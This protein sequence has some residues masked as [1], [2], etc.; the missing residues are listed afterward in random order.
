MI[1]NVM[2]KL[3]GNRQSKEMKRLQPLID[4]INQYFGQYQSLSDE[5]LREKTDEFKQRIAAGET[6]D[7]ILPEAFAVVKE[8]CRRHLGKTWNA[9]ESPITWDMVPFDVQLAGAIALHEGK[10]AEMAT[11]E[12]KTLAATMPLYLNALPGRGAHLVTVNDYL[13]RRDAEWMGEIYRFLGMSIG[14][15]LTN[16]PPDQRRGQYAC[17]ITYGTNN[18]FGFDY[19]RDNMAESV[20]HLVQR[21]HF[22]AIID[23]VD[24]VLIDEAR[25][26]LIIS[27]PVER[28]YHR[29][30]K[31]KPFVQTLVHNQTLLVN[32]LLSEAEAILKDEPDSFEAGKRILQAKKGSPK[33]TRLRKILAEP[34]YQRLCTRVE[35]D[36]MINK[37]IPELE[38][39]LFYVIDERGHNIDLTEQGRNCISPTDPEMFVLN[40]IVEEIQIIDAKTDID[41]HNKEE[42]KTQAYEK[43][44]I[45][46]E[47]LHNISQLLRAYSLYEQ[48]VEYIVQ[49]N[50]VI[51]VDEFTGRLMPGRRYSDGL[52]QALEAKEGVK[53]ER[54]TQTFATVTLQNFFRLYEKL[55]GMTGT[56]ETEEA[57]FVH[58]YNMDVNVM[59]TNKPVRRLDYN[60]YIYKTKREKYNAIIEEIERLHG[61][62]LPVLVGTVSVEVSELLSRMLRRK[63]ISHNVLNAKNHLREAEIIREAGQP[64][65]VTIAT[66]MAGRGTDIKLG[67][68]VVDCK[69]CCINC[70]EDCDSY[71]QCV[72][73]SEKS[74]AKFRQC[75]QDVPCGLY[76]IG[77]ERHESRRIDRQL[78]GRSGRQGD[79]GASR[80]FIS[81]EDDLMRLFGSERIS[82]IMTKLG[83]AE[84]ERIEHRLI[85]RSIENAQKKIEMIN[86][87]RRKHTLEYD[88][89]M[90]KQREIIYGL[91][92]EILMAE[93]LK[94]TI[95]ELCLE[96]T[97]DLFDQYCPAGANP[98]EWDLRGFEGWLR[99]N[100]M[101][102]DLPEL[103]LHTP[104]EDL[105]DSAKEAVR[106]G[107]DAKETMLGEKLMNHI[108]QFFALRA[109]D[110]E[111]REHLLAVDDL[112]DS[113]GLRA[114]AQRDPLQEYKAEA[115]DLFQ[116]LLCIIRKEIFEKIFR[117]QIVREESRLG[118]A[119]DRLSFSM[120]DL[121]ASQFSR[122][123]GGE[124]A[125]RGVGSDGG[126]GGGQGKRRRRRPRED[127]QQTFKREA[128]KVGRNDPCPC[129]S[130]KK[131]KKCCGMN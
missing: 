129:G 81:L 113:V 6:L 72:N 47:E 131:F 68:G 75:P 10:I 17:D 103:S 122:M 49:D 74:K 58:T 92:R 15:I 38:A 95:M 106:K 80:F 37:N 21:E 128:P 48:D 44:Q 88:N 69:D 118:P 71:G 45:K 98:D 28:S 33:H 73:D 14:C 111:W 63:G 18:E 31:M 86:F 101:F 108:A 91:R 123:G 76:I 114:Y 109:I 3:F 53:I 64:G 46:T 79:P 40:D 13:A 39:D 93:N 124:P 117:A 32:R 26:P 130:G 84:G 89:V 9:G 120:P 65:A 125:E 8:T 112:R 24:S 29:F 42:L 97:E 107:Y 83:L 102:L 87:E 66:N 16:M 119:H 100:V 115:F 19:L 67:K 22:Y 12:G 11:G 99:R 50:K 1:K 78:R 60:D 43:H 25:T 61:Q 62:R 70:D 20:E 55:S 34:K 2:S 82:Y 35:S 105:V 127:R 121:V 77:T 51:I 56:A 59:P 41:E 54:E 30:D 23:E 110:A 94:E 90:N 85:T 57:E 5:E 116:E 96:A 4:E 7:D 104:A 27:G 36:Y 126:E 52:H